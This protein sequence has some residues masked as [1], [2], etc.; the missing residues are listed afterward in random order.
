MCMPVLHWQGPA[1]LSP[2]NLSC[3]PHHE[4]VRIT[5]RRE[6]PRLLFGFAS[7]PPYWTSRN[8]MIYRAGDGPF[9]DSVAN[10]DG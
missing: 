5:I 9:R 6:R 7:K 3:L 10:W 8:W 2:A 4:T 1:R